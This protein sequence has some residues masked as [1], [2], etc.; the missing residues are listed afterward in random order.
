MAKAFPSSPWWKFGL[1]ITVTLVG[2]LI[3]LLDR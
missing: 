3:L 2:L 1:Y